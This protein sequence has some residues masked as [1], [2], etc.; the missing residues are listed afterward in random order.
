MADFAFGWR[1]WPAAGAMREDPAG[2][3]HDVGHQGVG[4]IRFVTE[5]S[6]SGLKLKSQQADSAFPKS[7]AR[8]SA[9][10]HELGAGSHLRGTSIIR[11]PIGA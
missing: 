6:H 3:C 1:R 9:T 4:T 11:L 10:V 2:H 8:G 5:S 7:T